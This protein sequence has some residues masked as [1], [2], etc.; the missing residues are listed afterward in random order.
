MWW[1]P[2]SKNLAYMKFNDSNVEYF[3]YPTYDGSPYTYLNKVRYPKPDSPNPVVKT[4]IYQT[5][6]D[7]TVEL[8][9]PRVVTESFGDFYVWNV[10]WLSDDAILIIYVNRKQNSAIIAKNDAMNGQVLMSKVGT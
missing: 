10:K 2:N 5:E 1:S 9:V 3:I 4:L 8:R 6:F 7:Q